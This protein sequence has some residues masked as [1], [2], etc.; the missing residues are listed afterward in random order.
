MAASGCPS[1]HL[2]E[3]G[4]RAQAIRHEHPYARSL[5]ACS[6]QRGIYL[7]AGFRECQ[8]SGCPSENSEEVALTSYLRLF[9]GDSHSLNPEELGF[10]F[11]LYLNVFISI[12]ICF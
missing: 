8:F 5:A 7:L 4:A 1:E 3:L 6:R 10:L 2:E 9:N 11:S 12:I